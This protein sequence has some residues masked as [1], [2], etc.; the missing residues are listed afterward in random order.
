MFIEFAIMFLFP[1]LM[2]L[3]GTMDLFTMTIPN[4]I[5]LGLIAGFVCLAPFSGMGWEM[6]A[7]H[8]ATGFAMLIVCIGFFAAGW[9]GGGDAK[10][11]AAASLWMGH[12]YVYE[13]ALFTAL[14]GGALTV[15]M[16]VA[17]SVP[18]PDAI[19]ANRWVA[20]LHDA[21]RGVPYG[22]ALAAAGLLVWPETAWVTNIL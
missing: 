7:L 4:R 1:A 21:G 12:Q 17:R 2:V 15:G 6:I 22:I 19:L 10:I 3:A 14:L 13:Y 18:L 5:A 20:R 8:L 11:F 9:V 16:L